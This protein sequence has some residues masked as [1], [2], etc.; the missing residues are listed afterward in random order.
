MSGCYC[1]GRCMRGGTCPAYPRGRY[2]ALQEEARRQKER[3]EIGERH[4]EEKDCFWYDEHKES[5][6][7]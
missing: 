1:T 3:D 6:H 2:V 5:R 4:E 7:V